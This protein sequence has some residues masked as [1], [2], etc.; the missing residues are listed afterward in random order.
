LAARPCRRR[1][2]TAA[3]A[4]AA[5]PLIALPAFA[6]ETMRA[7][8]PS[9]SRMGGKIDAYSDI[10]K[11]WSIY[12]PSTWNKFDGTPGEYDAKWQDVV[13]ATEQLIVRRCSRLPRAVPR[14]RRSSRL[15][16]EHCV[17]VLRRA[18]QVSS[19]PVT[20][21]KG[22]DALGTAQELGEKVA[23]S[24]SLTLVSA[25][26]LKVGPLLMYIVEISGQGGHE[27]VGFTVAK[28]KLW[29]I[30]AKSSEKRWAVNKE[31]FMTI[32]TSFQSKIL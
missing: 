1:A 16:A 15:T 22:I 8:E 2:V 25:E 31:M 24:R 30:T 10:V 12:K 4:S 3:L 18:A 32:I 20:S 17:R 7:I 13:G 19:S 29:R 28:G 26:A 23:K 27:A 9:I 11:G 5:L 14:A 21:G 6:D